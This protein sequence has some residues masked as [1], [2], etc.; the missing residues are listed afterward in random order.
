MIRRAALPALLAL[1]LLAAPALA[2]PQVPAWENQLAV[3]IAGLR[4]CLA[5]RPGAMVVDAWQAGEGQVVARLMIPGI[6]REDCTAD[7]RSGAVQSREP[8]A[9]DDRRP[10][11]GIR[12]FMLERRCVDAWR[13][14]DPNGRELGWLAYPEC[15]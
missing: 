9:P 15:G 14:V 2:Q 5:G 7:A 6:A 4:G 3:L 10:D 8:V 11:E 1:V 12:A 13:V